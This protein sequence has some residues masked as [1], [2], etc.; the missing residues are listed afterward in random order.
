[1]LALPVLTSP[2]G[3]FPSL[4]IYF[5]CWLFMTSTALLMLEV[6]LAL[7]GGVNIISMAGTTLGSFAKGASWLIYLFLFYSLT[8][9]YAAGCGEIFSEFFREGISDYAG[10]FLFILL[11]APV[12]YGGAHLVQ[13]FNSWFVICMALLYIFFIA[14]GID[15]IKPHLLLRTNWPLALFA[16]PVAFTA[17]A[18]H[19]IIPTLAHSMDYHPA[20]TRKAILIG[21]LIPFITYII[22]Q[23]LILGIVPYD[24][25]N[26]LIHAKTAISP[27]K[28]F[29]GNPYVYHI[30]RAFAFVAMLTSFF[31]VTLGLLD[32][33][34]DGLKVKKTPGGKALLC[35]LIFIPPLLLTL[36]N[37]GL[38]L[39]AIEYAGGFGCAILLG[40]LPILMAWSCRY[41]L[42]ITH[43]LLL[44]GNKPYLLL[45]ILFVLLEVALE[46]T[47]T[48][49]RL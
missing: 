32:F 26:G 25:P 49:T 35:S 21:S 24:T 40:L 7:K 15:D 10:S 43:H 31:G 34:A 4:G 38:F 42:N 23:C 37:P 12:V 28:H 33:L 5:L 30:G 9:A 39:I 6:C 14:I 45:L 29:T 46:I 17:F 20:N 22:W 16:L 1:M 19:G 3:F 47:L 41:R 13:R 8:L 27:L 11:F 48:L 44:P 2:G 36:Y 18:Y